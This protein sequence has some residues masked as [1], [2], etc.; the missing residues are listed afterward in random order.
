MDTTTLLWLKRDLRLH[1]HPALCLAAAQGVVLPVYI[2][3]PD[4]WALPDTSARQWTFIA[5]SLQDLRTQ[6]AAVGLPL[7]VR[8]GEAVAVLDRL[9]RQHGVTQ[10]ISHEETGNLWT[11][12]RDQRV[13]VALRAYGIIWQQLPQSGVV[14][15]LKGRNGW[16]AQRDGF[17]S[18]PQL[19]V[20]SHL[21]TVPGVEPGMIPTARALRLNDDRC[22]HRQQGGRMQ[23]LDLLD[24][25]LTV[26]GEP[27]RAAMSSPLSG[28]RACSRL[29]PHLALGALSLR[30]VV[31]ATFARQSER[32]AGR[33]AGA[34]AS[35]QSRIAWRDHFV[36]KLEDQPS[37]ETHCMQRAAE[38]LRPRESDAARLAAWDQGET[39][40]PFLDAC[41]RYL[42]ATGWLNFRMRSMVMACASYHLWL[43]WRQTGA[44]LAR[45]FTDYEPGIHWPQVQMQSGTT[46]M[47]TP[48]IYNPV[49][50]GWDQDPAGVFTRRWVPELAAVPDIYLQEPWKWA[51][52][53][54]VLGRRYPD[55]V[56]DVTAS[57]RAAR[58]AVWGLRRSPKARAEVVEIVER[59]ASRAPAR[60]GRRAPPATAGQLSLDL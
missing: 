51:G 49:K 26:R 32:P 22:P 16:A 11:Y 56:V 47:N 5:E 34:L 60:L 52:A 6:C 1:D 18:A 37:I 39:G 10:I 13:A 46:G 40:L 31:Q 20:P 25:F 23:G 12:R 19:A 7:V 33:W 21:R 38:L 17:V 35:F 57:M 48:R 24:S 55:P 43:D 29:S 54:S 44:I 36:Q 9:C 28:E 58:D 27:Y 8:V 3:E 15:C 53:G 41:L 59:H 2:V 4:Y 42:A 30:E 45:R 14:R 50:Q